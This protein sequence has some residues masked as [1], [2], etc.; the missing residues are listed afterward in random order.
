MYVYYLVKGLCLT[1]H[2]ILAIVFFFFF[3]FSV[4]RDTVKPFF[5]GKGSDLLVPMTTILIF[6]SIP[7]ATKWASLL[8]DDIQVMD[9][10]EE[11]TEGR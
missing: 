10:P 2:V 3:F 4:S 9:K 8:E 5:I 7:I 6:G 1:D 11:M